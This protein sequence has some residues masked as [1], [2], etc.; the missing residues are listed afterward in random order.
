MCFN[1]LHRNFNVS[2]SSSASLHPEVTRLL[3]TKACGLSPTGTGFFC[4]QKI[5]ACLIRLILFV[6][7]LFPVNEQFLKFQFSFK[8]LI[9]ISKTP[10]VEVGYKVF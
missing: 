7:G 3:K 6:V 9:A 10:L 5:S 4:K 8:I 1:L 2:K